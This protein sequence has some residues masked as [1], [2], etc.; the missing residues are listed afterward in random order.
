MLQIH[1]RSVFRDLLVTHLDTAMYYWRHDGLR[2]AGALPSDPVNYFWST[3]SGREQLCR[4]VFTALMT[5]PNAHQQS[6]WQRKTRFTT[7][8]LTA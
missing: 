2:S 8:S 6:R 5:T 4:A 7:N 1:V 3:P